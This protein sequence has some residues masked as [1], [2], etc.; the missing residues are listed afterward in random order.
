MSDAGGF[1]R[2]FPPLNSMSLCEKSVD[3]LP[4]AML[5]LKTREPDSVANAPNQRPPSEALAPPSSAP[6]IFPRT[7]AK[8]ACTRSRTLR[9]LLA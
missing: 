2:L 3:F 9:K 7:D 5:Q 8:P 4:A 1:R 6:E